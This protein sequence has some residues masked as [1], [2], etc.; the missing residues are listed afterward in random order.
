[1]DLQRFSTWVNKSTNLITDS[2]DREFN[3][4]W[5]RGRFNHYWFDMN[6]DWSPVQL[7]E[8]QA[9]MSDHSQNGLPTYYVIFTKWELNATYFFQPGEPKPY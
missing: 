8:S 7:P 1:M 9:R 5:P 3:E 6:R 4:M 2:N